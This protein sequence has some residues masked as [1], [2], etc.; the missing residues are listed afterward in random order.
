MKSHRFG[1]YFKAGIYFYTHGLS[2]LEGVVSVPILGRVRMVVLRGSA[3]C[4]CTVEQPN[5]H[6]RPYNVCNV[7]DCAGAPKYLASMQTWCLSCTPYT[8]ACN[9]KKQVNAPFGGTFF[10]SQICSVVGCQGYGTKKK[11][12]VSANE[13]S[14]YK[15]YWVTVCLAHGSPSWMT[16][17]VLHALLHAMNKLS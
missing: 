1:H 15:S 17:C 10:H 5:P 2:P 6:D 13:F 16:A 7:C 11:A 9:K 4:M 3:M 12:R 8:Q 14:L